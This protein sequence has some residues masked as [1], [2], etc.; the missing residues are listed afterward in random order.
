[1]FLSKS[2]NDTMHEGSIYVTGVEVRDTIGLGFY[3]NKALF[4]TKEKM[5]GSKGLGFYSKVSY[6]VL[7]I[8]V[9]F[10]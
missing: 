3:S 5:K 2:D 4:K 10:L 6:E 1:M 7:R 8:K 9:W